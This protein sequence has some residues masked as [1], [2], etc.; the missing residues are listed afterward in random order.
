MK[1]LKVG[2]VGLGIG[3]KHIL[4]FDS[5][6]NADV[7]ALCDFSEEKLS[8]CALYCPDAELVKDA[9]KIINNPEIDVVSI[10][11]FDNY[12]F[13]QVSLSIQ[14]GKHVFVE[15]PLCLYS[16]EAVSIKK[17]MDENP[18]IRLSSNLNLRTCPRFI[19]L[20]EKVL[21]GDMGKIYYIEGDY[22]WGRINKLKEGINYQD[23]FS[24]Q[25]SE[26][27]P[28]SG[29]RLTKTLLTIASALCGGNR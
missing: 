26:D 5:H 9:A 3:E 21:S 23:N 27:L 18:N 16:H 17:V 11:S 6:P 12:H 25:Y 28:R 7:A 14:N 19:Y 29:T 22:L 13:E 4:T 24:L 1:K 2:I 8:K 15:K 10:A 20:K